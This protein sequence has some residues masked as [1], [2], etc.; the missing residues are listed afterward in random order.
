MYDVLILGAGPSGLAAAIY[1]GRANLKVGVIENMMPGGQVLLTESVE[2]YPGTVK[3]ESGMELIMRF[4]QSAKDFGAEFI[5]DDIVEV[6]LA[7]DVKVLKGA[8]NEYRSKTVI[9]ATGSK[10]RKLDL[11]GESEFIGRG[12]SFCATCDG[13]FFKNKD[14]FVIGGGDAAIEE[15]VYLTRYAKKVTVIHRRDE[16]RAVKSLQIKAFENEKIDFMW[17]T[18]PVA[19][20]GEGLLTGIRVKDVNTGEEKVVES[21]N[22]GENIGVFIF[23]GN[24]PNTEKLVGHIDVDK[25]GFIFTDKEMRTNV[26]GVY[27]AGDVRVKTLRQVVTATADGAIAAYDASKYLEEK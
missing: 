7:G 10:R 6:E 5:H 11:P 20:I 8:N 25:S 4:E 17:N 3:G 26:S 27:A 21:S 23:V 22:A 18:V 19:F 14:V 15:A 9:I 1:A 2:N 16:L 24:L 12:I 13:A